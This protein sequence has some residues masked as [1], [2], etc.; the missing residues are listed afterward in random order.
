MPILIFAPLYNV[1]R[2][3]EFRTMSNVT[4]SCVVTGNTSLNPQTLNTSLSVQN[5]TELPR[6]QPYTSA[7]ENSNDMAP[8]A[9]KILMEEEFNRLTP[10]EADEMC[11]HWNKQE[12]VDFVVTDFRR[13]PDYISVSWLFKSRKLCVIHLT[14]WKKGKVI[15]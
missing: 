14:S 2:F 10:K 7:A 6:T 8:V 5:V 11:S 3:F 4:Y 12:V 1:P 15:I 9:T 13:N